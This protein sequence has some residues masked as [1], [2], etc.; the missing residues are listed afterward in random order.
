[1]IFRDALLLAYSKQCAFTQIRAVEALEA[2][3][4]I[5]WS[6]ASN[7]ERLDVRNGI[8]LNRL[9]H[10]LVD[11]GRMTITK[12]YRIVYDDPR[13]TK[14]AYSGLD[15]Q[16]TSGLHGRRISLPKSEQLWPSVEYIERHHE[17]GGWDARRL[18]T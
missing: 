5:P 9:H 7:S 6:Q 15:R 3:H 13:E 2:S 16:M 12:G 8:L 17:I 11:A 10:R 1:M 18:E 14:R 4:I